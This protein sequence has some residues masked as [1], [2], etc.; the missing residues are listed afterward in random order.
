MIDPSDLYT[1]V[2]A[3]ASMFL[4]IEAVYNF[5]PGQKET[6]KKLSDATKWL[7][8][9]LMITLAVVMFI[10]VRSSQTVAQAA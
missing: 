3:A 5:I 9:L 10:F 2:F 6:S 4:I 1:F 8:S 7:R